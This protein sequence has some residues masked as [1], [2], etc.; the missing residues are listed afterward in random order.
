VL[1][2]TVSIGGGSPA[3]LLVDGGPVTIAGALLAASGDDATIEPASIAV[4]GGPLPSKAARATA[5]RQDVA[6][7]V[8]LGDATISG[9]RVFVD[10]RRQSGP[11]TVHV[12]RADGSASLY[13]T[14]RF[15]TPSAPITIDVDPARRSRRASVGLGTVLAWQGTGAVTVV[16]RYAG[17]RLAVIASTLKA[18]VRRSGV[19]LAV[20][21]SG[22]AVGVAVDGRPALRT[23]MSVTI[24]APATRLHPGI[25]D[26]VTWTQADVGPAEAIVSGIRALNGPARWLRLSVDPPPRFIASAGGGDL[27]APRPRCLASARVFAE[28]SVCAEIAP[29]RSE[30]VAVIFHVPAFQAPGRYTLRFEI[31]GNFPTV[32]A[33]VVLDVKPS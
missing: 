2:G 30:A 28:P 19:S 20:D 31:T 4:T 15:A 27:I 32:H 11:V 16:R 13:G 7:R 5:D 26:Q 29:G 6:P 8:T 18:T 17:S 23:R 25:S 12:L 24:G 14:A 1:A 9:D 33:S 21:A 10:D 22:N 3:R